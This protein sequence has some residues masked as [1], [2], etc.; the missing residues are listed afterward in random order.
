[1]SKIY[2]YL[3]AEIKVQTK[4]HAGDTVLD[5]RQKKILDLLPLT[6]ENFDADPEDTD[7]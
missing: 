4:D 3:F 6:P 7:E 5:E 1:M 2:D